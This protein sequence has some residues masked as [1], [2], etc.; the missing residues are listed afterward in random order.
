M[1]SDSRH[2]PVKDVFRISIP[3]SDGD[4]NGRM[5]WDQT[6]VLIA[7]YG[8]EGFF[9]TQKGNIIV[10]SNGSNSW[11][12]DQSGNHIHVIQKMPVSEMSKFIEERMMH[13]PIKNK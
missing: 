4:K 13:I 9:E 6:A 3:L 11:Q 10:N 7:V 12:N 2:N 1:N 5:S 8:T